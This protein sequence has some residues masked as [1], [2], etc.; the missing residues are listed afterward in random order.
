MADRSGW[1]LPS[2]LST[3]EYFTMALSVTGESL[4][5]SKAGVHGELAN[6]V[7][8][9]IAKNASVRDAYV[10]GSASEAVEK[11]ISGVVEV[12]VGVANRP[13]GVGNRFSE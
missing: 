3:S 1:P 10:P 12:D 9:A 7:H 5:C 13:N 2:D 4:P 6:G 8:P 11:T